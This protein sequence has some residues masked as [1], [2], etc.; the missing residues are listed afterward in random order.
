MT[1]ADLAALETQI[2]ALKDALAN[3]KA[4][5]EQRRPEADALS[6]QMA[7]RSAANEQPQAEFDKLQAGI[8]VYW[9]QVVRNHLQLTQCCGV[10]IPRKASRQGSTSGP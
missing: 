3:A 1:N 5:I 9:Q 8:N 10:K 2:A 7:E 6:S 4:A